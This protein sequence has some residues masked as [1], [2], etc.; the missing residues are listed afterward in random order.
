MKCNADIIF[1]N[2][3]VLTVDKDNSIKEALAVKGNSILFVGTKEDVMTYL[4]KQTKLIDLKGRSLIPG[5]IDS[6]L[7][8][9]VLGANALAIDCRSPGV[10]SIEDIKKLVAEA[11]RIIPKG[12]WI[13]GWGYD[14]SKLKEGRHPNRW[15]LDEVAPDHPVILTR[16]CAHTSVHNS[17]SLQLCGITNDSEPISGGV[18]VKEN[19]KVT[20][21]L[22]ENSHMAAMKVS[23]LS[24]EELISA[25]EAANDILIK[26]GITS[27]H[28]SGG[29]GHAQMSAIQEAVKQGKLKIRLYSMIFS[30]VENLQFVEDYIHIGLHTGFGNDHFKIGPVK[31]MIDG[32]SSGPTAA[33]LEPYTS[34]PNDFGVLSMEQE[35]VNEII[36]KAHLAGY[37]VTTH[38]VGDKAVTVI[39]NA[40]ENALKIAPREDHRH[41]IEHC[42]MINNELLDR[43]QNLGII[44]VAQPI[45]LYEFG[46][47]YLVNYGKERAYRMFTCKSFLTRG[48]PVA[49][50][51]D[52]P[53]TFSSPILNMHL[54]V[55][56]ATESGQIINLD[57]RI[58]VSEALRMFTYNGAYA[59]FEEDIKGSLEP[60]KLADL[61][62]LSGSLL[63]TPEKEI[64]SL[65]VDMTFIDG[66]LVYSAI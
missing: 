8:S 18:L 32:S 51:S 50:S 6:H 63:D 31:L 56:R 49:G 27:V 28:D 26:E 61:T 19:G 17:K 58:S 36:L 40:I 47:G 20:G 2:G 52:C 44:P 35:K 12:Q 57:E 46:D 22:K 43:I 42:A 55:N 15:D 16:V 10:N 53:I 34:N 54:A 45:F 30:F 9:A 38:A 39:V 4:G 62:I 37:Q 33:T 21:V 3:P 24:I 65:K 5:F 1:I 13:R 41:R 14:H 66:E 29:Y 64:K 60:G 48:I 7:H 11:A 25:M 59:S 23:Q